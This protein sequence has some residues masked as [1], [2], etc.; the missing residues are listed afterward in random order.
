[1]EIGVEWEDGPRAGVEGGV[2]DG[3]GLS[4]T[5]ILGSSQCMESRPMRGKGWLVPVGCCSNELCDCVSE[6]GLRV[7]V[8][9]GIRVFA[10]NHAAS[11]KDDGDEVDAGIFEERC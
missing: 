3:V 10:I 9:D 1:M 6:G 11:G 2:E 5:H 4:T 8:E 7:Y